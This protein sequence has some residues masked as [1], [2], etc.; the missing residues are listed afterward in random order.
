MALHSKGKGRLSDKSLQEGELAGQGG[1]HTSG[2]YECIVLSRFSIVVAENLTMVTTS[3]EIVE[4][5]LPV[6]PLAGAFEGER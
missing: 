1:L 5:P 4:V 6:Q 3:K 2:N